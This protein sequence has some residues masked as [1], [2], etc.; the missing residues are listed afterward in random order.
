MSID[1]SIVTI[2]GGMGRISF[3]D[4]RANRYIE[5]DTI[6]QEKSKPQ[7]KTL[8]ANERPIRTDFIKN[9]PGWIYSELQPQSLLFHGDTINQAIYTLGYE[10]DGLQWMH[11]NWKE[12]VGKTK[13]FAAG[14][15][16]Q[17]SIRGSYAGIFQV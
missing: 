17:L 3:Y 5:W 13:L 4:I 15:P 16:L 12:S 1:R 7:M 8:S 6:N 9:S 11:G 2:G 10:E 14:G